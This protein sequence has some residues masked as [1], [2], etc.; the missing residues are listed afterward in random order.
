MAPSPDP[1]DGILLGNHV[2]GVRLWGPPSAPTLT[3][4]ASDIWDRRWF[5]DRDA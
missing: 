4:G 2:L 1:H 3:I 5:R